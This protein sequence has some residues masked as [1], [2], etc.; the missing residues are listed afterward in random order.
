L[1]YTKPYKELLDLYPF[2]VLLNENNGILYAHEIRGA[3]KFFLV[4]WKEAKLYTEIV[5]Y[6]IKPTGIGKPT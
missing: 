1:N 2:P 5:E 6:N 3:N 4:I